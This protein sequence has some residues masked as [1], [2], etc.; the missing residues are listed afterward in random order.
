MVTLNDTQSYATIVQL[1]AVP[2]ISI[3]Y[4]TTDTAGDSFVV[5][6]VPPAG[7]AA[8]NLIPLPS[9][10]NQ[11][12]ANPFTLETNY[13]V[14]AY[15]PTVTDRNG[16]FSSY[17][18]LVLKDPATGTP[19]DNNMIQPQQLG[20]IYAWRI[21]PHLA[22]QQLACGVEATL[23]SIEERVATSIQFQNQTQGTV[24]VYS[25]D[26]NGQRVFNSTLAAGE[27][28]VQQTFLTHPWVVTDSSGTCLGIWLP[29]EL[30]GIA[31]IH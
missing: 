20:Q 24:S 27:S 31:V 22:I 29:T 21:P 3:A 12:F 10:A 15:V 2:F 17:A 7:L 11:K 8:I 19:L 18:G 1:T 4:V 16:D 6:T 23:K 26:S 13:T 14:P 30:P 5:G 28:F 25:I 9:V